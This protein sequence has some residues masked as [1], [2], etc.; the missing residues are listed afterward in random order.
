L[1]GLQ[2]ETAARFS[3]LLATPIIAGAGLKK[4]YDVLKAGLSAGDQAAFVLGFL[5][6]ALTGYLCIAFLLHYLQRNSTMP[7]VWYRVGLGIVVAV[8]ALAQ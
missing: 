5:A 4:V 7:F 8:L 3:F 2:R 6:A 1:L